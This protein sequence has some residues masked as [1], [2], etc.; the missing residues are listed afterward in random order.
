MDYLVL[1]FGKEQEIAFDNFYI[2]NLGDVSN[3]LHAGCILRAVTC[4]RSN[5]FDHMESPLS[6]LK[7]E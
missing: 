1:S 4:A 7:I 5:I 2:E 3:L 6:P